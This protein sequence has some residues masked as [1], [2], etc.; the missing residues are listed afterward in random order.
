MTTF[1]AVQAAIGEWE[2]PARAADWEDV[3]RRARPARRRRR[4]LVAAVAGA[5]VLALPALGIGDRLT[6]LFTGRGP[7][8]AL[9]AELVRA[10]GTRVGTVTFRSSRLFVPTGRRAHPGTPALHRLRMPWTLS[11]STPAS[12]VRI[13]TRGKQLGTLCAPCGAGVSHGTLRLQRHDLGAFFGRATVVATTADGEARG[14]V[15]LERP[16]RR[17]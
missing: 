5:A 16:P 12:S 17:R 3:V 13:S 9:G 11:L 7:G 2:V 8:L 15:R 4:V 1:D 14:T 10:D 6:Q